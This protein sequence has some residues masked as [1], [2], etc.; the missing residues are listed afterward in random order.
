MAPVI[1]LLASTQEMSSLSARELT[2]LCSCV[3]WLFLGKCQ[4][5]ILDFPTTTTFTI[6]SNLSLLYVTILHCTVR[7]SNVFT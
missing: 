4:K 5:S 6:L 1:M 2:M 3:L 7:T